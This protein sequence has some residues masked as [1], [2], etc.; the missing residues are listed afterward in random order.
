MKK[1]IIFQ[2]NQRLGFNPYSNTVRVALAL[3]CFIAHFYTENKEEAELLFIMGVAV[4][5]ISI[6]LVFINYYTVKISSDGL[7][8]N[9]MWNR[10]RVHIPLSSII[11]AE[12][13]I[14][15]N[16]LLSNP[17]YNVHMDSFIV[18]YVSGINSVKI[19]IVDGTIYMIGSSNPQEFAAALTPKK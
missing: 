5:V 14:Y 17:V 9:G 6:L 18:F 7:R 4:S 1:D 13:T 8:I 10:R 3:F 11:S 19:T 12:A 2:E 16:T 15:R